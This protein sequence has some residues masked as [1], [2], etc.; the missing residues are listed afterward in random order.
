[1]EKGDKV[2]FRTSPELEKDKVVFQLGTATPEL[3]VQAA[4][5]V[6]KDVAAIDVNSGCPK[7]FSIHSG[8]GAALLRTPDTLVNILTALVQQ[9]GEP[10]GISISVK[11]RLL[12]SE[13]KTVAL[14]ERLVK[15]GIRNLTLHCRTTPM[16]PR[17][18]AI[19]DDGQLAKVAAICREAG[20][21]C[22]V[23]GDVGG[24]S[25]LAELREKYGVDGAMIARAAESNAS[26]FSMI[27]SP[28]YQVVHEYMD[29][30][31]RF[32]NHHVNAKFCL[33]RMIPGKSPVYQKVASARSLELIREA[34]KG[35]T[36][37]ADDALP[38]KGPT[39]EETADIKAAAK[40]KL[41]EVKKI[42]EANAAVATTE[43]EAPKAPEAQAPESTKEPAKEATAE[44]TTTESASE[45]LKRA[46]TPPAS[47]ETKRLHVSTS[48]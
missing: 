13:E 24:R 25:E 30:C 3:A 48:A 35:A 22:L 29:I 23:N 27:P 8:M 36:K 20:V 11:I 10:F 12:E 44:T 18:P 15:T 21:T 46:T 26:C 16:R 2:V 31:E 34:L 9:V 41:A 47:P 39:P 38:K 32:E 42:D 17:E 5:V 37:E 33:Q 43:P 19:H 45:P 28:W 6:A 4:K 7:H 14:V 40:K 1:M